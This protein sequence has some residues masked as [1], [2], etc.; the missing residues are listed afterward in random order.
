MRA[1]FIII[2]LFCCTIT[3]HAQIP[4]QTQSDIINS[5]CFFKAPILDDNLLAGID[6]STRQDYLSM[7]GHPFFY[8]LNLFG[9]P[10]KS[11]NLSGKIS[12]GGSGF[13]RDIYGEIR[14]AL[15][16]DL[17]R[18]WSM[19]AGLSL[20]LNY[21]YYQFSDVVT[22]YPSFDPNIEGQYRYVIGASIGAIYQD[23]FMW[24]VGMGADAHV[25]A[26]GKGIAAKAYLFY[27][28]PHAYEKVVYTPYFSY[29]YYENERSHSFYN[30][31]LRVDVIKRLSATLAYQASTG[32][33]T[34][35][36]NIGMV[37]YK[38]LAIGYNIGVPFRAT[39]VKAG[40]VAHTLS[41]RYDFKYSDLK[42]SKTIFN[43]Q[44]LNF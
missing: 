14:A 39:D 42:N 31:G 5:E 21:R 37:L 35:A 7:P 33:H 13:H 38:G 2:L 25:E 30:I 9:K 24:N 8:A 40:A 12:Q 18:Y 44:L 32:R 26:D 19:N 23:V 27:K 15:K 20:G 11:L 29:N 16:W 10:I 43:K 6:L 3:V 36:F 22:D 28:S 1:Y 17:S 4:T 41:L 34:M